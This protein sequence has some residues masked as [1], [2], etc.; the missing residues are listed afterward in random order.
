MHNSLLVFGVLTKKCLGTKV[1]LSITFHPKMDGKAYNTIQVLEDMLRACVI[2]FD[3][4]WDNHLLFIEFCY[5][6]TYR[7]GISMAPFEEPY[8][9]PCRSTVGWF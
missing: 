1:K 4:N 7:T 9:R 3:G 5:N 8:D 2:Y 6:N